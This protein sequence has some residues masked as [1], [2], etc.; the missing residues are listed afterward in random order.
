MSR[1]SDS[2]A[3]LQKH[4]LRSL[5]TSDGDAPLH[6]IITPGLWRM[7]KCRDV[8]GGNVTIAGDPMS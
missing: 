3:S 7:G 5:T 6:Q 1:R 2:G 8:W 4:D